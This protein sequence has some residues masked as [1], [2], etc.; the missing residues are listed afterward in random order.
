[1]TAFSFEIPNSSIQ[2]KA[3][4]LMGRR[5]SEMVQEDGDPDDRCQQLGE[6]RP[7]VYPLDAGGRRVRLK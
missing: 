2:E 3:M 7:I 5:C 4:K 6:G 1:M